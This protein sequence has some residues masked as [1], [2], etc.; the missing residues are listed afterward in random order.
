MKRAFL[1]LTLSVAIAANAAAQN[2]SVVYIG[3]IKPA[4]TF[5]RF[6]EILRSEYDIA[7]FFNRDW[8]AGVTIEHTGDS[9]LLRD[10]L[11]QTLGSNDIG[12][13]YSSKGQLF[14]TGKTRIDESLFMHPKGRI[15]TDG[16][17]AVSDDR[18]LGSVS[19]T[20]TVHRVTI[21]SRENRQ[22][23][24]SSLLSGKVTSLSSGEPVAGALLA[25]DGTSTGAITNGEGF[26]ALQLTP[27]R[28]YNISVTFL[29]MEKESYIVEMN[30]SGYLNVELNEQLI[31]IQE[32]V[33]RA[34]RYD[35]V[36]GMQMGFQRIDHRTIKSIPVVMGERDI[37]KVAQM[38]PG[39][40]SVGEGASGFN[41]RGSATDQNLFLINAIPVF[42]TGHLFG[43]FTA[44]NPDMV[45]DFSLYKSNFPVEYGGRLA[46]VFEV[47]TRRGNK[48]KFGARASLSPVTGSVL[49]ETPLVKDKAS[50]IIG[51]R[52]TYSN[53][54]LRRIEDPDIANSNASFYDIMAGVHIL[55]GKSGSLN[56]FGYH[57]DNQFSLAS[58][59]DYRYSNLGTSVIYNRDIGT[60]WKGTLA[61]VYSR[62][63]NYNSGHELP[64]L[65][66]KHEFVVEHYELK[67]RLTGYK[68]M[69]HTTTFGG[70]T[71][72]Y[73]ID[74][75]IYSPSGPLSVVSPTDF[76]RE[77]AIEFNL[78]GA[79]EYA[80]TDRLKVYGGIRLTLF[81]HLG[82]GEVYNYPATTPRETEFIND[83]TT[84]ATG[85]LMK[86][87]G[88]PEYR[89]S[90]N[91]EI[92]PSMS[93]KA[94]YNRMRQYLF[95]LS[96]TI[97]MSPID[98]W[99]LADP[100]I[101][102]PVAD[103]LSVG[104]YNNIPGTAFETSAEFYWKGIKNLIDY[105]D[106]ADLSRNER[107]ETSVLQGR[108]KALGAE[109]ML[110]RNA[111]RM[112]GW[113][114]YAY[115]RSMINVSGLNEWDKIN[116]GKTYPANYDKPHAINFVGNYQAS[117]RVGFAA[118]ITYSTGRPTTY[119]TGTLWTGGQQIILFSDRN[120]YRIPDYFRVDLS[121][122]YEGNLRKNKAAH[123]SW[124][125]AVYN[126][127][128]RRNV[129]S[130]YFK[131]EGG[132]INGYKQSIYGVPI[133]T[134]SYN[135]KLGNYA[136]E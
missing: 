115:S 42:N 86:S 132:Q 121:I 131:N 11:T 31:D 87:Y 88:G 108:Q 39:V 125:L 76:G 4:V 117:R 38:M 114:S 33:V 113:I 27:G 57:S 14:I 107:F 16:L 36:R 10:L 34:G 134:I 19:Y 74:Q 48:K 92:S 41:V 105:K 126:L 2:D 26:Y 8:V 82:P 95:M 112:T 47:S 90:M 120:Q 43:F 32:V 40:Q 118:N 104:I 28:T 20:P 111:G 94:G 24:G 18:R 135:I 35:N 106:G 91:Y 58:T 63:S 119:P 102:P 123:G 29:G 124:M 128:G 110:K 68:W 78:H 73:A 75:G 61:G 77:R 72:V 46:S 100:Y 79:D 71:I 129:Y 3:T 67:A 103:Q 98:R 15:E 127:T 85:S 66:F 136:V 83:T 133:F 70:G 89:L 6:A 45:S 1:I 69:N 51:G 122:N 101:K 109:F 25:V 9:I 23:T 52:S 80:I 56:I 37:I 60:V 54:I 96:N 44:F 22:T 5:E 55:T 99:K 59:N 13:Y 116:G 17:P 53:Y 49:I 130:V 84:Y 7:V 65:A 93:L 50:F 30:N 64:E 21:G 81:G 62:Y 12:F 97:A